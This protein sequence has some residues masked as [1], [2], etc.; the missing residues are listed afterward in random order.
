VSKAEQ[1][2]VS[3]SQMRQSFDL[4]QLN[5]IRKILPTINQMPDPEVVYHGDKFD[6]LVLGTLNDL[7][8]SFPKLEIRNIGRRQLILENWRLRLNNRFVLAGDLNF[9]TVC[10]FQ[11]IIESDQVNHNFADQLEQENSK[12]GVWFSKDLPCI[13]LLQENLPK[14][15]GDLKTWTFRLTEKQIGDFLGLDLNDMVQAKQNFILTQAVRE[16]RDKFSGLNTLFDLV[17]QRQGF[18]VAD[19]MLDHYCKYLQNGVKQSLTAAKPV[20][21]DKILFQAEKKL[22]RER[23]FLNQISVLNMHKVID[24]QKGIL[25]SDSEYVILRIQNDLCLK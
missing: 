22:W 13:A 20:E 12:I 4:N 3:V 19:Y 25:P 14:H 15:N 23:Q 21:A 2:S 9:E 5:Q 24:N 18:F 16:S 8:P 10:D 17:G 11:K 1:E 6:Y 7:I